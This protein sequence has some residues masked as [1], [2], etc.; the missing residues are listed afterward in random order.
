L[1]EFDISGDAKLEK[2]E[3]GWWITIDDEKQ[4]WIYEMEEE[5]L[6]IYALEEETEEESP[7]STLDRSE[8]EEHLE[9]GRISRE[10]FRALKREDKDRLGRRAELSRVEEGWQITFK[11]EERYRIE[12]TEEKLEIYAVEEADDSC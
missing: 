12:V 7:L 3:E 11:G 2:A 10:L 9:E 6:K 5:K 8:Y 4:Y 1:E